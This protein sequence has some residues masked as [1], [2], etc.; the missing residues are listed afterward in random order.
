VSFRSFLLSSALAATWLTL[1]SADASA[2]SKAPALE[3]SRKDR[4]AVLYSNQVIFDRTGEPLVSVRVTEGQAQVRFRSAGALTLLPAADDGARVRAP[5]GKSWTVT[6]EDAR[7]GRERFWVVAERLPAGELAAAAESRKRWQAKGHEV[8]VFEGGALIGIAGRTLDTRSLSIAVDPKPTRAE[9]LTTAESLEATG[10]ILGEVV[11]ESVERPGGWIV[12]REDESGVE[13]RARDLLWLSPAAGQT[14]DVQDVEFGR[15]TARPGKA[16]RRYAGD[17]YL[18]LG[19]DGLLAVVN[20]ASAE[21]L[22]EGTVPSELPASS[23]EAALEAQAIAARGQLLAKVGTRHRSDPYLLCA[24]THCQVYGGETKAHPRTTA[25]VR[26]T[27]GLL[28]FDDRGLVDTVYSSN[29]GGHTEAFQR[30]WGGTRNPTLE[31]VVDA[32]PGAATPSPIGSDEAAVAHHIDH[33]PA[34]AYCAITG[35]DKGVFRWSITRTGAEVTAAVNRVHPVGDVHTIRVAERGRSGRALAVEYVGTS[36][37]HTVTGEYAN[38]KL[39]GHLKSG[40]WVV[41]REAGTPGRAPA[42]WTF[43]GGGFGHGVGMCQHGAI[44]QALSKRTH[45]DI[46][47]VYYPGSRLEKAW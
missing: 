42:M 31:G 1:G 9:A 16:D 13:I 27:R 32:P 19:N 46:L 7:R 41:E 38:R 33:P 14:I 24:D 47:R 6:L 3:M 15:G 11:A 12:A 20:V 18:A 21:T 4:L 39:L 40:L 28:L 5:A 43:R 8:A 45:P 30:M 2:Q 25:A 35:R 36:G 34:G 17:L 22:L 26:A 23:P 10:T 44:G 37:R 29:C